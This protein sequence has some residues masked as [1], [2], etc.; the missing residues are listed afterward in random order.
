MTGGGEQIRN[1]VAHQAAAYD[2]YFLLLGHIA[3]GFPLQRVLELQ[4]SKNVSS[5]WI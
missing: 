5:L 3:L 4:C 1:P 2:P